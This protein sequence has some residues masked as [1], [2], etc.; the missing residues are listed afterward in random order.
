MRGALRTSTLAD[1]ERLYECVCA[2]WVEVLCAQ[3]T[4]VSDLVRV[5]EIRSFRRSK[6]PQTHAHA[7]HT[8]FKHTAEKQTQTTITAR[9]HTH[10]TTKANTERRTEQNAQVIDVELHSALEVLGLGLARE[11]QIVWMVAAK[12]STKI[13][14][15]AGTRAHTHRHMQTNMHTFADTAHSTQRTL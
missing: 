13:S 14:A 8:Q 1:D 11:L 15:H 6:P 4:W 9:T 5:S 7:T 10:E 12:Q 2:C 3:P